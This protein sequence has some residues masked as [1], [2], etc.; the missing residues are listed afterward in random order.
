[1]SR[2]DV[3]VKEPEEPGDKKSIDVTPQGFSV[4]S[5]AQEY[6]GG[7]FTVLGNMVI[8]SNYEDQ[9]LYKQFIG[10]G[11]SSSLPF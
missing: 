7:D 4:R 8:F 5:L 1:M 6:G 11:N 10:A 3:V 2:R 9:R